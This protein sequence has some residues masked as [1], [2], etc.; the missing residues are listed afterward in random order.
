MVSPQSEA[1]PITDGIMDS[2]DCERRIT[3]T[4]LALDLLVLEHNMKPPP[5]NLLMISK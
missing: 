3:R 2:R 1:S 5:R 4:K